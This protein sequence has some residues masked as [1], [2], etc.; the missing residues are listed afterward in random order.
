MQNNRSALVQGDL[1]GKNPIHFFKDDSTAIDECIKSYNKC[2]HGEIVNLERTIVKNNQKKYIYTMLAPIRTDEEII[3]SL[4]VKCGDITERKEAELLIRNINK[5]L[6]K[7]VTERTSMLNDA[8]EGLSMSNYEL[9]EM[10][11]ALTEETKKI[12]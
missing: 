7:K 4:G 5:Q 10:N 11:D 12:A 3:G 9:K 8:L 1:I 2:L 6:E